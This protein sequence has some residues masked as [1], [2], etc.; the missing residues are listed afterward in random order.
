[1][2]KKQDADFT[3]TIKTDFF[4]PLS[5]NEEHVWNNVCILSQFKTFPVQINKIKAQSS[6]MRLYVELS[7]RPKITHGRKIHI[8]GISRSPFVDWH[9]YVILID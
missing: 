5:D 1:M 3:P 4:L 7:S 6:L 2:E 9:A 8:I